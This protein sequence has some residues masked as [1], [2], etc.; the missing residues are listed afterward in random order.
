M[1]KV[2]VALLGLGVVGG[3]TYEILKNRHD[4]FISNE[5][6]DISI[7]HVLERNVERCKSL[8]VD[9]DIITQ[10]FNDVLNDDKVSIVAEFFGGVEPARTFL[11]EA[12]RRGKSVV[13]ANKEMVA[14]CYEELVSVARE[15][16]AGL[17]FEASCMGGV[18]IIRTLNEAMQANDILSLKGIVNGTTNYILTRMAEEGIDYSDCLKEAQRLGY[19]E[20]NP[21]ADVDGFDSTYKNSILS[22]IAYHSH[23]S[24]DDIYREGIAGVSVRDIEIAKSLGYKIKLLAISRRDGDRIE[25]RVHPTLINNENL[26]AGVSDVFNGIMISGD[27]VGDVMLYGRGAGALPTGSAIVSDIVYCAK[28]SEHRQ[29]SCDRKAIEIVRDFESA[30]YIRIVARSSAISAINTLCERRGL[31]VI[32]SCEQEYRGECEI[33]LIIDRARESVMNTLVDDINALACVNKAMSRIRID[34]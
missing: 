10:D 34:R 6:V 21:S 33:V 24:V 30:N 18:P 9:S 1:R 16:G 27:N 5:G 4:D 32:Y 11:L 17:Y 19:A 12:L 3:G 26:L 29:F 15:S 23:I 2:G 14:K 22:S 20:L 25:C 7:L 31:K 13:T 28:C 8:G